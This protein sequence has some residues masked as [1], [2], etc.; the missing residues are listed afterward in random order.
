M[1]Q[2]A[3]P[4][5]LPMPGPAAKKKATNA[6]GGRLP[7]LSGRSSRIGS[8]GFGL[9]PARGDGLQ[10][11][12]DLAPVRPGQLLDDPAVEQKDE[13]RPQLDAERAA[14]WAA[15]AVLDLDV[16]H[17]WVLREEGRQLRPQGAAVPSPVRAELQQHR[18]R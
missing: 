15:F 3:S 18:A 17:C 13:V 10:P 4:A 6:R 1:K 11:L 14:E 2:I 7:F 8:R 5:E 9:R 12:L 16:P